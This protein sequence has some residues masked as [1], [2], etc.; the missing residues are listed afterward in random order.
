[1]SVWTE[2]AQPVDHYEPA[3]IKKELPIEWTLGV[4]W[5]LWGTGH[6]KIRC[7][8]PDHNDSTPSFNL[9]EPNSSG[10]FQKMGCLGCGFR[11][12]VIDLIRM[13]YDVSYTEAIQIALSDLIPQYHASGYTPNVDNRE[14]TV[15]DVWDEYGKIITTGV[16]DNILRH[17]LNNKLMSPVDTFARNEWRW[18][19]HRHLHGISMPH[20]SEVGELTGVRFRDF[21]DSK[22]K[23]GILGSR[24]PQLYG[25]WRDRGNEDVVLCEGETDTV[26]TSWDLQGRAV[27]VF[28]IVTAN[29]RPENGALAQVK[30][31]RCWIM[32]DN[33]DAGNR[34][35]DQ[36]LSALPRAKRIEIPAGEDVLSCHIPVKRLL[37]LKELA[38]D[39]SKTEN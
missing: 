21:R 25:A 7:P 2:L 28:G 39:G 23:W 19:G 22:R 1:M 36:W 14:A 16:D 33:D 15:E 4:L 17:F 30:N 12:D 6:H 3:Y 11:A 10:V 31:R 27:D 37:S 5:D 38:E 26:W 34:A 20:F 32:F 29:Q 13:H 9:Y 35:A 8:M 24:F 18:K